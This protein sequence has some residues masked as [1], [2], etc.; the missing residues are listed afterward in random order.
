MPAAFDPR[1]I[2]GSDASYYFWQIREQLEVHDEELT[3]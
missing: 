2:Q 1:V 3:P